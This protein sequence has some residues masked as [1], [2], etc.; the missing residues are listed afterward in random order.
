MLNRQT[1]GTL[2]LGFALS[3]GTVELDPSAAAKLSTET[4][5]LR[6]KMKADV[7]YNVICERAGIDV[8]FDPSFEPRQMW[9]KFND[10]TLREALEVVRLQSRTAWRPVAPH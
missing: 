3:A 2:A 5:T 1:P 6:G 10:I 7:A 8:I 4:I 9:L